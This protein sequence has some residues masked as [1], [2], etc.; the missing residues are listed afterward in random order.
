M[1]DSFKKDKNHKDT[2]NK[3]NEIYRNLYW[4][5]NYEAQNIPGLIDKKLWEKVEYNPVLFF[6]EVEDKILLERLQDKSFCELIS[7]VYQEYKEYLNSQSTWMDLKYKKEKKKYI[8]YFSAEY[9]F[10]ESLPVYSGGL[11]ILAGDHCSSA[12]DLGLNFIGI[13]LLYKSG[14]FQQKID[15]NGYQKSFYPK[16]DFENLPVQLVKKNDKPLIITVQIN[17]RDVNIQIWELSLGRIKLY[18]LDTDRNDNNEND[19]NITAQLYCS[20]RHMRISQE[21]ILGIGG[22]RAIRKL[23]LNPAVWHLNEGHSAFIILEL[24]SEIMN[25][26]KVSFKGALEYV[27][28]KIVF[29]THTPV[30]EGNEAFFFINKKIF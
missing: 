28:K 10:H 16:Y 2:I 26:R 6:K 3:L 8:A 23:N 24:A 14:Y 30:K 27:K 4:I 15:Q 17:G 29:T 18:F 11:G 25:E 19:R 12:S 1:I 13:G 5:F 9:G 7:N 21:I 22:V 20:D